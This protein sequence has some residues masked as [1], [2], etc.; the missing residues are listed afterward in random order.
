VAR[1]AKRI[2]PHRTIYDRF[3]RWSRLGVFIRIL[4][5]LTAKRGKPEQLMIDTTHLKVHRTAAS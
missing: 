5:E 3:I 4:V 2:R 1:R